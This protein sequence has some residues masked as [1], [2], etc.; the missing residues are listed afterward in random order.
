MRSDGIDL[1]GNSIS[2]AEYRLS[3]D[4]A[5]MI[6]SE[7]RA[8]YSYWEQLRGTRPC[9]ERV[10]IDPR[11]IAADARHLFLLEDVGDGNIR[12]RLAGTA[13]LDAFGY[14]LRGMSA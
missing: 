1:G 6:H 3:R 4:E 2:L 8:V 14:D 13:L 9:P 12:F 7:V 5:G 10:E 11:D